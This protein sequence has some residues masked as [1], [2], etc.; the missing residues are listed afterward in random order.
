[1]K[2][3]TGTSRSKAAETRV[4]IKDLAEHAM[5]VAEPPNTARTP[6]LRSAPVLVGNSLPPAAFA[7]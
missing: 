1:L 7:D 3:G 6:P 4:A 2:E 5:L